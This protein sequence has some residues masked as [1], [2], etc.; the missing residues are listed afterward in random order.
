MAF[1]IWIWLNTLVIIL[2]YELNVSILLGKFSR[3]KDVAEKE[4]V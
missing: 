3:N 2:G 4:A 1:M